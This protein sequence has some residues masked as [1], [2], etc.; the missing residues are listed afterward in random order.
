MSSVKVVDLNEEVKEE[1]PAI[2]EAPKEETPE[3]QPEII[4]EVIEE[5]NEEPK[6]EPKK[7]EPKQPKTKP[8]AKPKA[9]DIVSCPDCS[10]TMTYKNLRYSH[11]C[12]PEPPPVKKQANPKPKAKQ[13][14]PKAVPKP[15][16]EVYY[17]DDDDDEEEARQSPATYPEERE[18]SRSI[19]EPQQPLIKKKQPKQPSNPLLGGSLEPRVLRDITNQYSLLHQ[20]LMQQRQDK[21]NKVC[22]GMF[23]PRVKKR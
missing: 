1:T 11:K 16:P 9:S 5:G 15:P 21:Y 23:A 10:R 20:Q 4:N 3:E 19:R 17:S 12:S 14:K 18:A 22:N 7:E 6:E 8:K 13:P 2:E